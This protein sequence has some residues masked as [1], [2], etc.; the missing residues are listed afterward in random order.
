[1]KPH[2]IIDNYCRLYG[3]TAPP[4]DYSKTQ[5]FVAI[6]PG[7]ANAFYLHKPSKLI[8]Q[9]VGSAMKR[10]T[11]L[12]VHNGWVSPLTWE[13]WER[14]WEKC[15]TP[16]RKDKSPRPNGTSPYKSEIFETM[17]QERIPKKPRRNGFKR[18]FTA[19]KAMNAMESPLSGIR[20][21]SL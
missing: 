20:V 9:I 3:A 19:N 11:V 8:G 7:T 4:I 16:K 1:M 2:K 12:Y 18:T 6:S 21:E 13:T 15:F 17:K 10:G 14:T 5:I